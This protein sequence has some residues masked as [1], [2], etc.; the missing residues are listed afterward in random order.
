[1]FYHSTNDKSVHLDFREA[2][3]KGQPDDRGLF[4][5][6]SIPQL[7]V[8][9]FKEIESYSKEE[10]GFKVIRPYTGNTIPDPVLKNIVAETLSFE[11]PLKKLSDSVAV[12]ELFHGPTLAFKDV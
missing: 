12:L 11:F 1:M 8:S 9:F 5:P 2:T 6:D 10:I 7:P 4:F 3:I